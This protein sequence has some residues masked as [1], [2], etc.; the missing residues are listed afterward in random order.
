MCNTLMF[1]CFLLPVS[2]TFKWTRSGFTLL[3]IK[4][5]VSAQLPQQECRKPE[6]LVAI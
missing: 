2:I 5:A 3:N 6:W 1:L 4:R